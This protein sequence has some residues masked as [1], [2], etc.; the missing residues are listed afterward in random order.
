MFFG[1]NLVGHAVCLAGCLL[2]FGIHQLLWKLPR[3]DGEATCEEPSTGA[4][5][6]IKGYE[7]AAEN[8]KAGAGV[9]ATTSGGA[10]VSA[11]SASAPMLVRPNSPHPEKAAERLSVLLDC[12]QLRRAADALNDG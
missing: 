3:T 5:I 12:P 10:A 9:G 6:A 2:G 4:R 7:N 8:E 11:T 1:L